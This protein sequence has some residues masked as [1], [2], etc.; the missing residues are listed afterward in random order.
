MDDLTVV[1]ELVEEEDPLAGLPL[2]ALGDDVE[3]LI[4]EGSISFRISNEI[5][6]PSGQ[7]QLTAPGLA[8][9][10]RLTQVLN[11]TDHRIAVEGHTDDVRF[12]G[13]GELLDNWDL[14]VKRATSIVRIL[15][16]GTK[17]SPER[18]TAAG[19]SEYLPLDPAKTSEARQRN[20][21]TEIILSPNLDEL[22]DILDTN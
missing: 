2:D 20:R 3:I 6:F 7:A 14:S 22:F 19:R 15:L 5:L 8:V 4:S 18:I 9:L 1:A 12:A 11:A 21:R 13:R 17:I 10:D 16:E